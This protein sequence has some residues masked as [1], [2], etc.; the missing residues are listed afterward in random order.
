MINA[1]LT[2]R[3]FEEKSSA[4]FKENTEDKYID[5]Q[6]SYSLIL[7]KITKKNAEYTISPKLSWINSKRHS[8]GL[9]LLNLEVNLKDFL[10]MGGCTVY[11]HGYQS[12][13]FSTVYN[14]QE[15][16]QSPTLKFLRIS[17]ENSF[18]THTAEMGEFIAEGLL[19][20]YSPYQKKGFLI[21]ADGEGG[22]N[23]K[24]F[25]KL[26]TQGC[27]EKLSV[28]YDFY[29]YP[30]FKNNIPIELTP[31]KYSVFEESPELR[32]EKFGAQFAKK[33]EI[34]ELPTKVP[35]GWC[36]WYYYYTNISENIILTNL[37]ESVERKLPFDVFQIDDGYQRE[38][39]DW[40]ETNIK[41]PSGMAY[42]AEE[43]RKSGYKPGLWLAPFI[44][45][46]KSNFY[47]MYPEAIL[48]DEN[49]KPV[50]AIWNPL[51]GLDSMYSLDV[52]HPAAIEMLENVF[53]TLVKEYG[54]TY[55]KLD[56]LFAAS[57]DGVAYNPKLT[58]AERYSSALKL[59]RKVVGKDV[60]LLGCGAPLIPSV[61]IFDGMRIGCD[62]TPFWYASWFR[63]LLKDKHALCTEKALINAIFR[64]FWHK[65][66]WLNDPDCLLVRK[67]KNKMNYNQTILMASVI[68]LLGGMFFASDNLKTMETER[69]DLLKKAIELHSICSA[70][71][72]IPLDIFENKFPQ[73][74][75]NEAGYV[76]V[77]NS[78]KVEKWVEVGLPNKVKIN[79]PI[80][81]WTS[82]K[83]EDFSFD[84]ETQKIK[85]KLKPHKAIVINCA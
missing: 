1:T 4:E 21:S 44:V 39:G 55:L 78:E 64:N 34:P 85:I 17:E 19:V 60:F 35:I 32:L 75:Y 18:T 65:N 3:V 67:D 83:V 80:D 71:R 63:N 51:W 40:L 52:T 7:N 81:Y 49:E 72:A 20:V 31:I 24:F 5:T 28:I 15:K 33:F 42:L 9:K 54:Y 47:N 6:N 22:Q 45:R 30:E 53:K 8:V 2:S 10:S 62:V 27:V 26:D 61:G 37:R 74:V 12:W 79:E 25:V 59:I 16:D 84:P 23:V 41:F 43:I 48:K 82:E 14:N 11:Q 73:G 66:V 36:S 13:S 29:C 38:I 70:K 77:W 69:Y 57:L 58:P 68:S 46:K 56:F 50:K 76:G